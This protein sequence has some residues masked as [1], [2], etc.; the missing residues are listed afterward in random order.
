MHPH[1]LDVVSLVAGLV[2]VAIGIGHM[3]GLNITD[4]AFSGIWPVLAILGGGILLVRS[5]RR[6]R[7]D[8]R[9]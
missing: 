8:E 6:A 1:Q 4:V 2:F 3:I 9:A 5:S 7:D